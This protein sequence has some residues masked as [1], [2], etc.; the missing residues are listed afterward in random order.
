MVSNID[1]TEDIMPRS[2]N[3]GAETGRGAQRARE[4]QELIAKIPTRYDSRFAGAAQRANED[5]RSRS[6]GRG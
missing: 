4:Q 1:D 3:N 2:S 6:N 5:A